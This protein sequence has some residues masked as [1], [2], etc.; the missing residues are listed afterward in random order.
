M[1]LRLFVGSR[2]V[3]GAL[4][5]AAPRGLLDRL[6]RRPVDVGERRVARLLGFRNLVQCA[7]VVRKHDRAWLLAGAVVDVTHA[8]SMIAL[9]L[10]RPRHRRLANASALTASAAAIAGIAATHEAQ[11]GSKRRAL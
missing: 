3:L 2:L 1:M 9:A 4:L 11:E 10:A 8:L 5:L 7:V 6:A